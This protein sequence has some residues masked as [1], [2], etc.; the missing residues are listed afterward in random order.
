M[1]KYLHY[2][3]HAKS[4]S[5]KD[6]DTILVALLIFLVD[7]LKLLKEINKKAKN[8]NKV[9]DLKVFELQQ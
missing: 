9:I 7:S 2:R 1:N 5:Y 6:F 4:S 8:K 3:Y